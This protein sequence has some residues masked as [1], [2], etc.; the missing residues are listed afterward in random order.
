MGEAFKN[1]GIDLTSLIAQGVNFGLLFLILWKF[2][3]KPI[4]KMLDAR[5]EKI[6]SSLKHAADIEKEYEE[7][8]KH[9]E[10]LV[11]KVNAEAD[12]IIEAAKLEAKE[13]EKKATFEA[14]TKGKTIITDAI[15]SG[16]KEK[17]LVIESAKD[18]VAKLV[19]S[20]LTSI[21]KNDTKKYDDALINEALA[22]F[23]EA[24]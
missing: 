16:Q 4:V 8:E 5:T 7:I 18:E 21:L 3:Y 14:E 13:I 20:S 9:K 11:V 2:L 15:I 1:L 17:D 22:G 10:K 24:K 23:V 19:E 6:D 12:K